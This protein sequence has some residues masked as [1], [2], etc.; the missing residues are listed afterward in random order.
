MPLKSRALVF[1]GVE[2]K[3]THLLKIWS[4]LWRLVLYPLD[5]GATGQDT[6]ERVYNLLPNRYNLPKAN[7]QNPSHESSNPLTAM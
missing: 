6:S 5:D 7:S 2:V 4:E 1:F 3:T